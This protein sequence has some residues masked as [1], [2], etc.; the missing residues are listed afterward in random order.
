M[1]ERIWRLG[2]VMGLAFA[3]VPVS[4]QQQLP[5]DE[6]TIEQYEHIVAT[7][8][9]LEKQAA[10]KIFALDEAMQA[11]YRELEAAIAKQLSP[12]IIVQFNGYGGTFT[13]QYQ[14]T[15]RIVSPSPR[16]YAEL[17]SVSH[18]P[19]GIYVIIAPYFDSAE[20]GGWKDKLAANRTIMTTSLETIKHSDLNKKSKEHC[21]QI[22]EESVAYVDGLLAAGTFDAAG[23]QAYSRR[24]LLSIKAN[25]D[26]AAQ[27]QAEASV[28]LLKEWRDE[29]GEDQWRKLWGVVFAPHTLSVKNASWQA[30]QLMMHEETRD[31]QL[32]LLANEND[33]DYAL[34]TVSH[35]IMDRLVA[36]L[37]FSVETAEDRELVK[38]LGS[39]QDLVGDATERAIKKITKDK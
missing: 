27:L 5:G 20:G 32:L 34:K 38:A 7:A 33:I 6:L 37:V 29:L 22:L 15:R 9:G 16:R 23:F 31:D 3:I 26:L 21:R 12:I 28:S 14:G 13:L 19:L 10:T 36:R 11:N 30:M 18:V 39:E 17:K 35:L 2:L 1:N 4:A 25:L 24:V 8:G